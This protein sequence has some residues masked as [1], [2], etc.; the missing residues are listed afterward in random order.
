MTHEDEQT[1]KAIFAYYLK[2][3]KKSFY[4]IRLNSQV[5]YQEQ[6][7]YELAD[8]FLKKRFLG[9]MKV[10]VVYLK[11]RRRQRHKASIF[12]FLSL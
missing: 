5:R 10:G 9:Y 2:L 8:L 1:E 6:K 4:S 11:E 7:T 12:R 3:V